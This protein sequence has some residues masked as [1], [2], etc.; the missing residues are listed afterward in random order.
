MEQTNL[1]Q[2]EMEETTITLHLF[3]QMMTSLSRKGEE[4]LHL[5]IPL[6]HSLQRTVEKPSNSKTGPYCATFDSET[7]TTLTLFATRLHWESIQEQ[8]AVPTENGVQRYTIMKTNSHPNSSPI[9]GR[10]VFKYTTMN[11]EQGAREIH[12][13]GKQFLFVFAWNQV[14]LAWLLREKLL[15]VNH[16]N[17]GCILDWAHRCFNQSHYVITFPL[18]TNK[19]SPFHLLS[20]HR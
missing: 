7:T 9:A 17:P 5:L 16:R 18:H 14:I 2:E 19:E 12:F 11:R 13:Q 20:S 8:L 1:L 10:N 4:N 15:F 3:L 6:D